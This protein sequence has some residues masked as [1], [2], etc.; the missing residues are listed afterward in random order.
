MYVSNVAL[1]VTDNNVIS[2]AYISLSKKKTT[3]KK[4]G[5]FCYT[6]FNCVYGKDTGFEPVILLIKQIFYHLRNPPKSYVQ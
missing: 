1:I 3:K 4:G 2:Q 6:Q 5:F